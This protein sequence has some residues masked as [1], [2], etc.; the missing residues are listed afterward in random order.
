MRTKI[1]AGGRVIIPFS[2]RERMHFSVG[3]EIVL[4]VKDEGLCIT[5]VEQAL[6]QLQQKVK[7]RNKG[8]VSLV[9]KLLETR[10]KEAA[11]E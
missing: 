5:T 8:R 11:D 6:H 7:T 3:D 4:H 2:I 10:R 9:N 1:G